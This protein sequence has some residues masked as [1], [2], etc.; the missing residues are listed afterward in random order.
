MA[1]Y[2]LHEC[3]N[4]STEEVGNK[5][6]NVGWLIKN[7]F[8]D[9]DGVVV[10]SGEFSPMIRFVW[11]WGY[12][13]LARKRGYSKFFVE[14]GYLKTLKRDA[15]AGKY[16]EFSILSE[17]LKALFRDSIQEKNTNAKLTQ[18]KDEVKKKL[19][20]LKCKYVYVRSSSNI[21]DSEDKTYAG[22]FVSIPLLFEKFDNAFLDVVLEVLS[23]IFREEALVILIV[24]Y[25]NFKEFRNL[26]MA[27]IFQKMENPCPLISG[28]VRFTH[29]GG[30]LIEMAQGL[31]AAIMPLIFYTPPPNETNKEEDEVIY[32]YLSKKYKGISPVS[33]TV[34]NDRMQISHITQEIMY[35]I[36]E[37][38]GWGITILQCEIQLN[39]EEYINTAREVIK[40]LKEVKRKFPSNKEFL[41]EFVKWN[42]DKIDL[43][44]I[45]PAPVKQ[46]GQ[47][48]MG[49]L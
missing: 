44:Q 21:E 41:V 36:D 16:A 48:K 30:L 13:E 19:N 31:G 42:K 3:E 25:D 45:R 37:Y 2:F 26:N 10:S 32:R 4:K 20:E 14:N 24:K 40:I 6:R 5:A 47:E 12:S 18:I 43:V 9:L 28:H 35:T 23:G 33:V 7:G 17:E 46:L 27:F 34:V 8:S 11:S 1:I 22:V 49:E 39:K 38:K 15:E 29:Y